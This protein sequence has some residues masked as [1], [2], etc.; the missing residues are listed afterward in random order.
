[1]E[2]GLRDQLAAPRAAEPELERVGDG[3]LLG[4]L[5][6]RGAGH[7]RLSC[8]GFALPGEA[9]CVAERTLK[10]P[11]NSW[12]GNDLRGRTAPRAAQPRYGTP[13]G[14]QGL[15]YGAG[16]L[17]QGT[18]GPGRAGRRPEAF[19]SNSRQRGVHAN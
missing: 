12:R 4:R 16:R 5:L 7:N 18:G 10:L 6:L 8:L 9:L 2:A 14:S 11:S 19:V 17:G 3:E 13:P 15:R 1:R